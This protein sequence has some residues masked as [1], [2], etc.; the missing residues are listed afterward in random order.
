MIRVL[1]RALAVAGI[2]AVQ[3]AWIWQPEPLAAKLLPLALLVLAVVRPGYA[4]LVLASLAPLSTPIARLLHC[5]AP[6]AKLLEQL[7]LA[8]VAGGLIRAW[9]SRQ[10]TRL[11]GP[12]LL[13]GAVAAAS[14]L[15]VLPS[16]GAFVMPGA[17]PVTLAA[18]LWR[19]A[20]FVRSPFSD[21]AHFALLAVEGA[22][23]G[24]TVERAVRR[25]PELSGGLLRVLLWG[26]AGAS[27][28]TL[29]ALLSNALRSGAFAA[30]LPRLF[31]TMRLSQQT[32]VNAAASILV[33]ALV[34]SIGVARGWKTI[35]LGIVALGLWS[36]G[37]RIAFAGLTL[38]LAAPIG[39]AILRGSRRVRWTAAGS[40]AA[41]VLLAAV[42]AIN[43][44][45]GRNQGLTTAVRT[46]GLLTRVALRMTRSAP[47]F[48][49]GISRFYA[50]S[51]EVAG[52][53]MEKVFGPTVT[54][55]NA[56]NNFLQVLAEQGIV[57]L[58]C[59]L[60]V[61][62][63]VAS[64]AWRAR[65][66][67][68]RRRRWLLL[69]FAACLVTWLTG[70]PML[71]P[72]FAFVFWLYL[73]VLAALTPSPPWPRLSWIWPIAAVSILATVPV[74]ARHE[75]A[76][77]GLEHIGAGL[78]QWQHDDVIAYRRA[79]VS[80][81]LYVAALGRPVILPIRRAPNAPD[82]LI[83]EMR[84]DGRLVDT[85]TIGGDEWRPATFIVPRDRRNSLLIEFRVTN[86]ATASN[87]DLVHLGKAILH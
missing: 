30:N 27:A 9:G 47:V 46:R 61:L 64:G 8:V 51:G 75:F 14:A 80:F 77:T 55:E 48:G 18:A 65:G 62:G 36:A 32:D 6:G 37:S 29:A 72:E 17:G 13:F 25:W 31:L 7:V 53:E 33:L 24:W 26:C 83:I 34:A 20:Y 40:A 12:G 23:L 49:V 4:L 10:V 58:A 69:G 2:A 74:R 45:A 85:I 66:T 41:V 67:P 21:P 73:G 16:L 56:H 15:T 81:S 70:H 59:L 44:P 5:A 11:G 22:L 79:G 68:D 63:T 52:P 60:A 39:I 71:V 78:S 38:V 50:K 54:H 28:L 3:A 1:A 19:D 87:A 82:P 86:A 42:I 57:G 76:A 43:Y 84:I 35:L